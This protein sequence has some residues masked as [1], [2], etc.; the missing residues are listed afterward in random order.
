MTY[1]RS[2]NENSIDEKL[3]IFLYFL[4][5][6]IL[7]DIFIYKYILIFYNLLIMKFYILNNEYLK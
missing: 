1:I 4:I 7:N 3:N 2:H 5:S 6:N